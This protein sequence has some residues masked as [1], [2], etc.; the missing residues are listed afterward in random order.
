M[1]TSF[2]YYK[3]IVD[4]LVGIVIWKEIAEGDAEQPVIAKCSP[5]IRS[6]TT[7]PK[8]GRSSVTRAEQTA[9]PHLDVRHRSRS[10]GGRQ[11]TRVRAVMAWYT[12]LHR[13]R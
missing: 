5:E 13:K 7:G 8:D 1:L 9:I 12:R 10:V 4:N 3:R 11:W 2:T 6:H